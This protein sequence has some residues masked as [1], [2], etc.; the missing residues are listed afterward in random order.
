M[1]GNVL[2]LGWKL[3]E[4]PISAVNPST[5]EFGSKRPLRTDSS[6]LPKRLFEV[7]V[8]G[9]EA[10]S[11]FFDGLRSLFVFEVSIT[12]VLV[13]IRLNEFLLVP[14]LISC[15]VGCKEDGKI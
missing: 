6:K 9:A 5:V 13:A 1:T 10:D 15:K 3:P 2:C 7:N 4:A 8:A 11:N 14:V 12:E